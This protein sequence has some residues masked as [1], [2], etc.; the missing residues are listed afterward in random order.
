[1]ATRKKYTMEQ[2]FESQLG[3]KSFTKVVTFIV[4]DKGLPPQVIS[5]SKN[6]LDLISEKYSFVKH[7]KG[8]LPRFELKS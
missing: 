1:M 8:F 3:G 5:W 7:E 2:I 4:E 6:K